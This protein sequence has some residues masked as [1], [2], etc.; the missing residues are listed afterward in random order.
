LRIENQ[1]NIEVKS[2]L[3]EKGF[4]VEISLKILGTNVVTSKTCKAPAKNDFLHTYTSPS[5]FYKKKLKSSDQN[6]SFLF[7]SKKKDLFI[8]DTN[9]LLRKKT[10]IEKG[11]G[12]EGN[13]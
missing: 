1:W 3:I 13:F 8:G 2:T 5:F 6:H 10:A 11:G 4:G 7:A 9:T 12:T